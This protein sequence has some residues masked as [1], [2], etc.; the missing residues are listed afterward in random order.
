MTT[1][2][3]EP[4]A[5][6]AVVTDQTMPGMTGVDLARKLLQIRPQHPIILCTG[7]SNLVNE[8]QAKLYGIQGFLMKPLTMKEI[9]MKLQEVLAGQGNTGESRQHAL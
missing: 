6:D 3:N 5:F 2:Q 8:E 9:G 4:D 7:Y 1:F